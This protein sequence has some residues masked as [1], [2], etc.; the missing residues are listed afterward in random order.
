VIGLDV[1]YLFVEIVWRRKPNIRKFGEWLL[2]FPI[3]DRV[4][5]PGPGVQYEWRASQT[6]MVHWMV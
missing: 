5:E 1:V 6:S 3:R 2:F 4:P